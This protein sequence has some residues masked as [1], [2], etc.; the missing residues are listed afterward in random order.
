MLQNDIPETVR[1]ALAEDIGAGDLTADLIPAAA[2]AAATIIS[3]EPA[4]LCGTAWVDEVFRQLDSTVRVFWQA[5]DGEGVNPKQVLCRIEGKARAL[6]MGERTAL[7]FLQTLS[8]TATRAKRY[9]D[10]VHGLGV[11]ILDTRKT[12]PGLRNAQKYAVTCGGCHNHRIG[13][14]DGILV[15][16][17]HIMA[18]GSI[19]A[20]VKKAQTLAPPGVMLEVE[21]ETLEELREA[22]AAGAT[23]L[24]LDNF[25]LP[26]MQAAVQETRGRAELEA[27]G[28]IT[29]DNLRAIAATG[30]DFISV[31][32]LTKNVQAADLSM[33][34]EK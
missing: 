9:A 16:E 31:G 7:N 30:V 19:T 22:L 3:R 29:F 21:V 25:D 26:M 34:F 1:I 28:G 23:R 14:F 10:A 4:I 11:K 24:L 5:R 15:K 17:N 33:R 6:L 13:L 2:R 20:A 27:S 12:L 8:G 32:D 18:A